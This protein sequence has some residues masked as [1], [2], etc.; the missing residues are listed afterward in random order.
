LPGVAD[1]ESVS[2]F[3]LKVPE[4]SRL[5]S[6]TGEKKHVGSEADA[7]E[8]LRAQKI[9]ELKAVERLEAEGLGQYWPKTEEGAEERWPKKK[10][11]EEAEKRSRSRKS[12]E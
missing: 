1:T 12:R 7:A 2:K 3:R 6:E 9:G 10:P 11:R 8:L 4:S 5:L